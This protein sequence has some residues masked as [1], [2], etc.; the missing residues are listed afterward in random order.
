MDGIGYVLAI[1]DGW[2]D[3]WM[4]GG[5]RVYKIV[6][7]EHFLYMASS[8]DVGSLLALLRSPWRKRMKHAASS[9]RRNIK[10]G[11]ST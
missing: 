7:C 3:G 1:L 9:S 5:G 10:T 11:G 2:M 6:L 8:G 4:E